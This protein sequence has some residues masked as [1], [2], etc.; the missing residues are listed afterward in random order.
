LTN[1]A[2]PG[3]FW[4]GLY[5]SIIC[6]NRLFWMKSIFQWIIS[7]WDFTEK[8]DLCFLTACFSVQVSWFPPKFP[9]ECYL[10]D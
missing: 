7:H 2:E 1:A 5:L 9:S 8:K 4:S 10:G 6:L 3:P